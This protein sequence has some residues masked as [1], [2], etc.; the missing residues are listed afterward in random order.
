VRVDGVGS[1]FHHGDYFYSLRYDGCGHAVTVAAP[2]RELQQTV[3]AH[4]R[5]CQQCARPFHR[6]CPGC[7]RVLSPSTI[8]TEEDPATGRLVVRCSSCGADAWG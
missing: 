5:N 3:K 7:A 6:V 1:L 2:R 8:T 4:Y